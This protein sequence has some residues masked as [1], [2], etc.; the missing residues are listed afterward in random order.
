MDL[1]KQLK[2]YINQAKYKL[3]YTYI[4]MAAIYYIVTI[5]SFKRGAILFN[6]KLQETNINRYVGTLPA[7]KSHLKIYYSFT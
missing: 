1:L 5:V 4:Y 6:L 2:S 7:V 3:I